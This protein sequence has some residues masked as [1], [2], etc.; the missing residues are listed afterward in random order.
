MRVNF[1]IRH[2][3]IIL[4]KHQSHQKFN[5]PPCSLDYLIIKKYYKLPY[6]NKSFK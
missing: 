6:K 4:K 1:I 5:H 2:L 3:F